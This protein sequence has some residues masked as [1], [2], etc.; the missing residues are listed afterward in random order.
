MAKRRWKGKINRPAA[1]RRKRR[2]IFYFLIISLASFILLS[3]PAVNIASYFI[4]FVEAGKL[5]FTPDLQS[6][7]S[8]VL[9][10]TIPGMDGLFLEKENVVSNSIY[11]LE[12]EGGVEL[13][14]QD[15]GKQFDSHEL[16][17]DAFSGQLPEKDDNEEENPLDYLAYS[18]GSELEEE[19]GSREPLVLIYHT[20]ASESFIPDAGKAFTQDPTKTVVAAGEALKNI[21]EKDYGIGVIH[22]NNYYDSKRRYAYQ[23]AEQDL[24]DIISLFPSI[25]I[26]L[27]IHR[28]GVPRRVSTLESSSG[29][30]AKILLVT[31]TAHKGWQENHRFAMHLHN[32]LESSRPGLSRGILRQNSDYNQHLHPRSLIIELGGHQNSL[33]EVFAT[34][35]Y[36]AEALVKILY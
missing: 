29:S 17:R 22:H 35:P 8:F 12:E 30:M 7:A 27:D 28:D 1:R 33:A 13:G 10:L 34:L 24:E 11:P 9:A 21:L 4:Y 5:S 32:S 20:H 3:P 15:D 18:T 14:L 19:L 2:L 26:V 36:F 25:E 6:I 31:G 23:K 16:E